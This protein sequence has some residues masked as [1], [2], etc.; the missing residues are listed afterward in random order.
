M[1]AAWTTVADIT[2][3]CQRSPRVCETGQA[4]FYTF[5]HKARY[6]AGLVYELISGA[7]GPQPVPAADPLPSTT[8]RAA[9]LAPPSREAMATMPQNTLQPSDLVPNWNGPAPNRSA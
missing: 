6:G 2:S 9:A 5:L 4:A 3:I 7:A 8:N 1:D